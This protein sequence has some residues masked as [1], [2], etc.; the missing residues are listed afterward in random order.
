MSRLRIFLSS[1]RLAMGSA[2]IA[3]VMSTALSY[4][5]VA[6]RVLFTGAAEGGGPRISG[7]FAQTFP[8]FLDQFAFEPEFRGGA[9]VGATGDVNG[10]GI[11]DL[12]VGAGP[13][14]GPRLS[15][16][17]G[18]GLVRNQLW[19][20]AN[21]YVADANDRNG[22]S[23]GVTDVNR[24]GFADVIIGFRTGGKPF[25]GQVQVL[26]GERLRFNQHSL[27]FDR[28]IL[29]TT[30]VGTQV[31]GGDVDRDGYGDLIIGADSGGGPV[32]TILRGNYA[33]S[34]Q[35]STIATFF[36][37]DQ[38]FRGGVRVGAADVNADG[39]VDVLTGPGPGGGP[40]LNIYNGGHLA[41]GSVYTLVSACAFDCNLRN[42][43]YVGTSGD[44]NRD[45]YNE[46][47]TSTHGA[48]RI[49]NGAHAAGGAL[50]DAYN[51]MRPYGEFQ[52]G[53]WSSATNIPECADTRDNDGDGATDLDDFGCQN[54][55]ADDSENGPLAACQDGQDNDGDNRIDMNDPGCSSPQDNDEYNVWP[56]ATPVPP[57]ATP[58]NTPIPQCTAVPCSGGTLQCPAGAN[59][60]PGGCGRICVPNPTPTAVPPTATPTRTPIP[61]CTAVACSGGTLQCP[62]NANGCPG[63]CGRICVP[64]PTVTPTRTPTR[65]PTGVP[66][67]TNTPR[68]NPTATRT[69]TPVP[70]ST[71][72][73][74]PIPTS[75]A[76]IDEVSVKLN[77]ELDKV[78]IELSEIANKAARDLFKVAKAKNG[79][80]AAAQR[81]VKRTAALTL[82]L[83][84][85][86]K[87]L[88]FKIPT[89]SRTCPDL[90]SVC[91]EIDNGPTIQALGINY[92]QTTNATARILNRAGF[93]ASNDTRKFKAM[94]RKARQIRFN[95]YEALSRVPKTA[96]SCAG[97]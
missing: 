3:V 96:I 25:S 40:T 67:A 88:T 52:G 43:L 26:N 97:T 55:P 93:T 69:A 10:D 54:N 27:M 63:G 58:T 78:A 20:I 47:L 16:F 6:E 34:N 14:G 75:P 61:Q 22:I 12:V 44:L 73:P 60:C 17:D 68:P 57:T 29:G 13:S 1:A 89:V 74:L 41:L 48:L 36:A 87:S 35:V 33:S 59:G 37:Y 65:T 64:N 56:T 42:G 84:N 80:I 7:Y 81:D 85:E 95:G 49:F 71:N 23:V 8:T 90:T 53:L 11:P 28:N 2:L 21:M 50:V 82:R 51:Q 24:D 9:A 32:V 86:A 15:V 77:A 62:A 76:C 79:N 38:N 45:G 91:R 30:A 70:T 31:A 18:R 72:T 94:I 92:L 19:T 83:F 4:S 39:H 5:A 46:V 66:S